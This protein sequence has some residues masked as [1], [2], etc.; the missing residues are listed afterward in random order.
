MLLFIIYYLISPIL[1][2]LL[3]IISLFNKKI[4]ILL[5]QQK[6]TIQKIKPKLIT[7]KKKIIIHAAS[8]GEYEQIKPILK[9]I[10]KNLYFTIITCMSPTIY[11]TIKKDNL[12]DACCYHPFD[13][14]WNPRVF[15]NTI[16]PSIYLTTRHD[17]WPMHL[18]TAKKNGIKTIII[19][20]NL[21]KKSNRLKWYAIN[22]T[23]YIFKLF[24]LIMVPSKKVQYIFNEKLGIHNTHIVSDT[25]FEQIINRKKNSVGISKFQNIHGMQNII[26]GSISW[27]D[28]KIFENSNFENTD[29]FP[30]YI[31]I[32]PHEIDLNLINKIKQRF[33]K[34]GILSNIKAIPEITNSNINEHKIIIVD[35]VGILP[36]LYQYTKIAYVGGGFG[37]GVH[38]TIEP[39][40]YNNIV[41]YGPNIDILDEAKEMYKEKCGF[42]INNS[43]ELIN[44]IV[45]PQ[46]Q[47]GKG[48]DHGYKMKLQIKT[49]I[50]HYINEKGTSSE[51]IHTLINEYI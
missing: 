8:A 12:S 31:I 7:D 32:V 37:K 33:P 26:F 38:S 3:L 30:G 20:A 47:N 1:F 11:Q 48:T 39:L 23:K 29:V 22:F 24:D 9:T 51:K 5:R 4:W 41:C 16:N 14:P 44:N 18:H 42:I 35:E 34:A 40:V 25:R 19:N 15:F 13:F 17:I 46:F 6:K 2:I 36:E 27:E 10:N 43:S 50:K 45:I 28:L 49:N 21:Y